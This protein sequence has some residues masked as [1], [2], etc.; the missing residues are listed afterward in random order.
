M[1]IRDGIKF[2]FG[3]FIGY[4]IAKNLDELAAEVYKIIKKRIKNGYC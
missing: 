3:F 2:G 1:K 4:E